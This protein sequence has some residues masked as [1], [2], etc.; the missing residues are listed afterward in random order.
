VTNKSIKYGV[1][2]AVVAA[3]L[4][5]LMVVLANSIVERHWCSLF[6]ESATLVKVGDYGLL[7]VAVRQI[8]EPVT[9]S[10]EKVKLVKDGDNVV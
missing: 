10:I 7:T 4:V 6:T 1:P 8:G 5:V 2:L 3:A 9:L